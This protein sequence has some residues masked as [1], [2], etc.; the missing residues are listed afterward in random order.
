MEYS[1]TA[2]GHKNILGT[3]KKTL[4]FTKDKD[5]SL[6][7]DC[8]VGVKADFDLEKIKEF[9][10]SGN[11]VKIILTLEEI[12]ETIN[13]TVNDLFNDNTELVIRKS[14][15]ATE[16]TFGILAD[17]AAF[18]LSREFV[19]LLKNLEQEMKVVISLIS[20]SL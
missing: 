4:E 15:M 12:S 20:E 5:L 11:K 10:K 7:G 16:R 13:A 9:I 6:N 19:K 17:K 18:D 8:I 3:H 2:Y 1:F 14:N